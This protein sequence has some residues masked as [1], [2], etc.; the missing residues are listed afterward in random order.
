MH[1]DFDNLSLGGT[2][3]LGEYGA[4]VSQDTYYSDAKIEA[5]AFIAQLKRAFGDPPPLVYFKVVSWP[6][7]FGLFYDVV[8]HYNN[9]DQKAIDYAHRCE[10]EC[11]KNWDSIACQELREQGHSLFT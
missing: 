5:K 8:I 3:P 10:A 6:Y 1:R 2:I 7:D 11:P 9:T 4:Q